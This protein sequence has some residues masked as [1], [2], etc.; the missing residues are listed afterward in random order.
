MM[1]E[2]QY[3]RYGS[4]CLEEHDVAEKMD[5]GL[6]IAGLLVERVPALLSILDQFK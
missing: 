3:L 4:E 5:S 6:T 2:I 1:E